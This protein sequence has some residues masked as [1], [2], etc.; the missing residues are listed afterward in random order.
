[1]TP[2]QYVALLADATQMRTRYLGFD[3]KLPIDSQAD[4]LLNKLYLRLDREIHN[5][6]D[7]APVV[8]DSPEDPEL[9]DRENHLNRIMRVMAYIMDNPAAADSAFR[10]ALDAREPTAIEE[11]LGLSSGESS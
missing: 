1:M 3:S 8:L 4:S 9:R 5:L 2:Q 6:V 10:R 11:V 7:A